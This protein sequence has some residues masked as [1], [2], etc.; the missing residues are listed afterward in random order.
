MTTEVHAVLPGPG[1][2]PTGRSDSA[3]RLEVVTDDGVTLVAT[4]EGS[5]PGLLL[6]HG[7][8]GAKEDF[9]DHAPRLAAEYTVVTFDHRGHGESDNPEAED[10]YSF[11]RL[12]ADILTVADAAGLDTFVLLGHSMGGMIV[13]RI[14]LD[15]PARV[16]ALVMMDTTPGPI[17][18]MDPA[19]M[20]F[21]AQL[22][23][24]EGKDALKVALDAVA[25]L[26]TEPYRQLLESRPGYQAYNDYKWDT[27]SHV[28]WAS[29]ARAIARQPDELAAMGTL[30]MPVLVIVGELDEAFVEPSNEMHRTI[31]GARLAVIPGAGHSPQFENGPAWHEVMVGFV[32]E[33]HSA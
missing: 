20:E 28:M 23:L 26:D 9:A 33:V 25:P 22:A 12:R 8:G 30:D 6:V 18:S 2:A 14:A 5:G 24:D 27:L 19:I 1:A 15:E 32:R 7:F 13:R 31:P 11:E 21:G 16:V 10:A 29:L 17:P 3:R 4:I